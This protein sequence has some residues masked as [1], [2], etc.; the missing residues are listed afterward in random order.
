M[1]PL[2][3]YL[4]KLLGLY[5]LI[6]GVSIIFRTSHYQ[7]S[8]KELSKSEALMMIISVMPIVIG[9]SIILGHNVWS[10]GWGIFITV[11]G[12]IIFIVGL[13]RL[14]LYK[15]VMHLISKKA[16]HKAFLIT[17]GVILAL[18]GASLTYFGFA[19]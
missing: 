14:F 3:L 12:W 10:N 11:L 18:V 9:L 6:I 1:D 2:T 15:Q 8:M 16:E 4:A 19:G 7:K 13:V 5:F 17:L